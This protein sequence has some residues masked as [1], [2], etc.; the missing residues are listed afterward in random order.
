MKQ[1]SSHIKKKI[2]KFYLLWRLNISLAFKTNLKVLGFFFLQIRL[3]G[4][5]I[6]AMGYPFSDKLNVLEHPLHLTSHAPLQ[7]GQEPPCLP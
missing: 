3:G 4:T 1:S 6:E 2:D 7:Q 5:S